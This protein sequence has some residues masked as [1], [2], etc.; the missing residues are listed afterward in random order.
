MADIVQCVNDLIAAGKLSATDGDHILGSYERAGARF[1]LNG[2]PAGAVPR[3]AAASTLRTHR[4]SL[5]QRRRQRALQLIAQADVE[6]LA[7]SHQDGMADGLM[8]LLARDPRNPAGLVSIETRAGGLERLLMADVADGLAKLRTQT[9]GLTQ[10]RE[11]LADVVRA[12]HG[13]APKRAEASGI[14]KAFAAAAERA[15]QLFNENGGQIAKREDWGWSHQ[16]DPRLVARAGKDAWIEETTKLLD[17]EK[18]LGAD[19]MPLSDGELRLLLDGVYEKIS[20]DGLSDLVPGARA[21]T[22]LA[23]AHQDRRFLVFRDGDAW[24]AYHE[25]FGGGD[26]FA[27]LTGHLQG[28]AHEIAL[29]ERFGP[30]PE[31]TFRHVRDL[32][33][34]NGTLQPGSTK[35]RLLQATWN[36]TTGKAGAAVSPGMAEAMTAARN[37]V[38]ATRLGSAALSA[39]T[40]IAFV[41]QALVWNGLPVSRYIGE[42]VKQLAELPAGERQRMAVRMGMGAEA[43]LTRGLAA[44]RFAEVTGAGATAKFAD[45]TMRA[46]GLSKWT[47]AELKAVGLTIMGELGERAGSAHADLHPDLRKLMERFGIDAA[48]WDEIRAHGIHEPAPGVP[49]VNLETL[50]NAPGLEPARRLELARA[51]LDLTYEFSHLAV[52]HPGAIERAITSAGLPRG[53]ITGEAWR[54]VAQ[55]KTFPLTIVMNHVRQGFHLAGAGSK[56]KYLSS[57]VIGTTIMGALA[58]QLKEIS[59]G[60]DPRDMTAPDF[61]GSAFLQGG[62]AGIYG[63]F[64]YSGLFGQSRFG[65]S[66]WEELAGPMVGMT[67]DVVK[68]T[69]G[70]VGQALTGED[71]KFVGEA[72]RFAGQNI[73]FA[74]SGWYTRL[75]FE[76][77][78]TDQLRLAADPT[79]SRQMARAMRNSQAE[80]SQE[81]WW[82]PGQAA[83]QRGPD[84]EQAVGE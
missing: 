61:W 54:T 49:Y 74:S 20:T 21:S 5:A 16:H 43:W 2:Y 66:L 81:F 42:L 73:P 46:S 18:M 17:R 59:K 8:A 29:L 47:D 58:L 82:Q 57:L 41:R 78:A 4:A 65:R 71:P 12:L 84:L 23:N 50:M 70:N 62:G 15:R 79:S 3:A 7:A 24:L 10:D 56:A 44:N 48:A 33:L 36:V 19:L 13:Q 51:L 60:R 68:L 26:L 35:D 69:A 30:N 32:A 6:R 40:D 39:V 64:L 38:A 9:F 83:P 1:G 80:Y 63:D 55:F 34:R 31:T 11:L 22:K 28:M 52:P 53:T 77:M 27:N 75:A 72:I 45:F 67:S 14:A 37:F 76:R 25:K